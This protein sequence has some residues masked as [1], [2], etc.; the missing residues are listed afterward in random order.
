LYVYTGTGVAGASP[1]MSAVSVPSPAP[2]IT[3]TVGSVVVVPPMATTPF[4]MYT[5]VT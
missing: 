1:V 2:G 3:S 5:R 4:G